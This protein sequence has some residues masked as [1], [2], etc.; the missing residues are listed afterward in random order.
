MP[1]A[2]MAIVLCSHR[3]GPRADR[4]RR[5]RARWERRRA[6]ATVET[7]RPARRPAVEARDPGVPLQQAHRARAAGPA[8]PRRA[9]GPPAARTDRP[10]A[11]APT[12]PAEAPRRRTPPGAGA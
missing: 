9:T 6:I 7:P 2:P 10:V 11:V 3:R 8:A 12:C 5:D 4:R 1:M